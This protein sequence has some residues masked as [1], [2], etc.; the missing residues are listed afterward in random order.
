[1]VDGLWMVFKATRLDEVTK[2]VSTD[3]GVPLAPKNG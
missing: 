2:E 1:M 3:R